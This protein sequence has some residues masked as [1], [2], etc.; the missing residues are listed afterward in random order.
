MREWG[1]AFEEKDLDRVAKTLH[2]DYRHISYPRSLGRPE[3]NREE[4]LEYIAGVTSLWTEQKVGYIMVITRIPF[5]VAKSLPQQTLHSIIDT[6][7]KVILHVRTLGFQINTAPAYC[8]THPA[9][10]QRCEDL[11][12]GRNEP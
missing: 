8:V 9:G 7:G 3:K 5:A 10:H 1:Q 11:N 4:W 12:R 2:K 6:P